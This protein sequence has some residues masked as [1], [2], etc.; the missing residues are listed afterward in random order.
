MV[1][2]SQLMLKVNSQG[3]EGADGGGMNPVMK[4]HLELQ[5]KAL[6]NAPRNADDPERLLKINRRQKE[7]EAMHIEDTERL[8]T[9]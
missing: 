4:R 6:Q 9:E 5:I 8:V 7:E 1:D 2:A 3:G